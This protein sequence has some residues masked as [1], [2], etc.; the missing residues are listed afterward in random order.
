MK[1]TT[2]KDVAREAGV[3]ITIASFALNNVK[4]RVSDEVKEKVLQAASRLH[5]VPNTFARGLRSRNPETI[6]LVYSESYL[7]ER[8]ASTLQFV[9]GAIKRAGEMGKDILV[10]TM[11]DGTDPEM[12]R[13]IFKELWASGRVEGIIFQT[14]HADLQLLDGLKREGINFVFIPPTEII[15]GFNTVFIDNF[16]LMK[17]GIRLIRERGYETVHFLTPAAAVSSDR[18][19][20]YR[21]GLKEFGLRGEVLYTDFGARDKKKLW[22][23]LH[24]L[25]GIGQEKMAI[26]CWND[27]HAIS[28]MDVLHAQGIRIPEQVGVMGFDDIPASEHT[29]PPLATIRQPFVEMAEAA[30][31]LVIEKSGARGGDVLN[32]E[33]PGALIVRESL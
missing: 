2:I 3:S 12:S 33:V 15:T 29:Y 21:A 32:I 1:R 5:Y 25:P 28:V 23:L 11:S 24:A 14:S 22:N 18:E 19:K 27:V 7:E 30:V 26:A 6:A 9:A 8:N 20:G 10:K 13:Q 4:G 17:E 31:D 16:K